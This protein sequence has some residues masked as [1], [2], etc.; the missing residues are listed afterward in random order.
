MKQIN[1]YLNRSKS[2]SVN[3]NKKELNQKFSNSSSSSFIPINNEKQDVIR[4][5]SSSYKSIMS[6]QSSDD[7]EVMK[8]RHSST[9]STTTLSSLFTGSE[10]MKNNYEYI[11][12]KTIESITRIFKKNLNRIES[13][14]NSIYANSHSIQHTN[15]Q[16][17]KDFLLNMSL[18]NQDY[19]QGLDAI[20]TLSKVNKDLIEENLDF[21]QR[22]LLKEESEKI[23]IKKS[24]NQEIIINEQGKTI[25]IL[26]EEVCQNYFLIKEYKDVISFLDKEKE[27]D[28]LKTQNFANE[29]DISEYN[30][31]I[32][33]EN[34]EKN[35][36]HSKSLSQSHRNLKQTNAHT[37]NKT[38]LNNSI[39]NKSQYE[40][41]DTIH[42]TIETERSNRNLNSLSIINETNNDHDQNCS[43]NFNTSRSEMRKSN[44]KNNTITYVDCHTFRESGIKK[45]NEKVSEKVKENSKIIRCLSEVYNINKPSSKIINKGKENVIFNLSRGN[46]KNK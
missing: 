28:F 31:E 3:L 34:F 39:S 42:N 29:N 40:S 18:I 4:K 25:K 45:R 44:N 17:Y 30:N 21:K 13:I 16:D 10:N 8:T 19:K 2:I 41:K 32:E 35:H 7:I 5:N 15:N 26:Q 38:R 33:N 36:Y 27:K 20:V 43:T 12:D 23:L 1:N 11:N 9:S 24:E 46:W 14:S 22:L 37:H 6:I